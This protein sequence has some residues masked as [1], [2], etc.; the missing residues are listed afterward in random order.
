[1]SGPDKSKRIARYEAIGDSITA[2]WNVDL[3]AGTQ[4]DGGTKVRT[5][6]QKLGQL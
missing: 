1:M 4:H 3:P 6:S 2:G 5:S